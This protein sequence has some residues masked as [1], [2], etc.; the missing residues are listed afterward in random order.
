M[1]LAV[2]AVVGC[3]GTVSA[4]H[5]GAGAMVF[6]SQC[7]V[8][9]PTV[10]GRNTIGPSLFSVVGRPAGQTQ[11][12]AYSAANRASRL[13]WDV[14]TLDRYL[15]SPQDVMPKTIMPYA[16]LKDDEKRADL[17]AYLTTLH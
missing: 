7:G 14:P 17:I 6:K 13:T 16:G 9:H 3:T 10:Q 15:A 5:A 4:Q 8:C 1:V 2:M 12:F 11:G